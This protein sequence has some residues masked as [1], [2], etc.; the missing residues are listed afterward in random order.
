MQTSS[1]DPVFTTDATGFVENPFGRNAA[2]T[3]AFRREQIAHVRIT[4]HPVF[5]ALNEQT[6]ALLLKHGRPRVLDIGEAM[7]ISDQF[8]FIQEGVIGV[9]A[10][11]QQVCVGVAGTGAVLGLETAVSRANPGEVIAL[12]ESRVFEVAATALVDGLGSAKVTELCMRQALARLQAMQSE[13]ACNA[14]HLVPQRLAKWLL[15]LHRANRAREIHLTQAELAR[16]VG[17]QRTSIN[18]AAR[19]L[20]DIGAARFVR[21]RVIVQDDRRLTAAACGCAV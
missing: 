20:Q 15:R 21:G 12:A 10:L 3:A 11:D 7:T 17:V 5:A 13:A 4:D 1:H 2:P 8:V 19:Q 16:L 6:Q 9:F 18:G 14:A